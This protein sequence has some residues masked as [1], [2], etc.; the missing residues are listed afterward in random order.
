MGGYFC[1]GYIDFLLKRKDV[2][3]FI[4]IFSPYDFKQNEKIIIGH[5]SIK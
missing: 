5:F 3:N 4:S 1:T 2:T